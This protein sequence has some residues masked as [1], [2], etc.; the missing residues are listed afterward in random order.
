MSDAT[1]AW[2]EYADGW[3]ADPGARAYAEA[4]FESLTATLAAR[5]KSLAGARVLDF[6][7]GTGLLTERLSGAAERVVAVDLSSKMV[8]QVDAKIA[9]RGWTNVRTLVGSHAEAAALGEPFDLIV[10]SSVCAFVPDYPATVVALAA[11][12]GPE[13]LFVQWDWELD[14]DADEPYGLTREAIHSALEGASLVDVV[15]ETAF[16]RPMGERVMRPLIGV[17]RVVPATE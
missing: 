15:V 16:E 6:G 10:C 7:C 17:G 8:A 1:N 11:L 5:G 3:D 13:G 4:A 9:D 2:D 12:L 14:P